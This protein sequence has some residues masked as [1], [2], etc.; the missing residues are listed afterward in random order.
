[1]QGGLLSLCIKNSGAVP[2]VYRHGALWSTRR[3][4]AGIGTASVAAVCRQRQGFARYEQKDGVFTALAC[5][6]IEQ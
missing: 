5:M 1:M 6:N 4:A 2:L 3:N